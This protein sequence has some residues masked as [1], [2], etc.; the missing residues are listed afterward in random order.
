MP[1][2]KLE[3]KPL[4]F[5][6]YLAMIEQ[7]VGSKMFRNLLALVNGQKKNIVVNGRVACAFYVSALLLIFKL[8]KNLHATVD[9]TVTD[10]KKFGWKQIKKP[11]NGCI[12]IWDKGDFG[13][14][15]HNHIGFYIGDNFAVSNSS[16]KRH[17]VKHH[18]TY[19]KKRKIKLLLW[20]PKLNQ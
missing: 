9:G 11:R 6:T 16:T 8:I 14:G 7:S 4:I 3:V 13:A 10:L 20:H 18:W 1:T 17:P 2:R 19:N 12:I 5:T 15:V